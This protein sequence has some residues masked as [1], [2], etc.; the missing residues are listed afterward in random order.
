M[1]TLLQWG[2]EFKFYLLYVTVCT[3]LTKI[4][5]DIH[6]LYRDIQ[7]NK[8]ATKSREDKIWFLLKMRTSQ[9]T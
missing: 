4:K 1:V 6:S 9:E 2:E 8:T 5:K 3:K 7:G